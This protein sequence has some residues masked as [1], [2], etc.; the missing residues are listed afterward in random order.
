MFFFNLFF[1]NLFFLITP[2]LRLSTDVEF[3]NL[4]LIEVHK[5]WL[6]GVMCVD[7][8]DWLEVLEWT[9]WSNCVTIQMWAPV[10]AGPEYRAAVCLWTE[11]ITVLIHAFNPLCSLC[12]AQHW[13]DW[14]AN[15]HYYHV[16][17]GCHWRI[18]FLAVSGNSVLFLTNSDMF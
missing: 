11:I 5:V 8:S 12:P 9:D 6:G 2:A 18:R 15:L 3:I 7:W 13:C 10:C 16:F 14:S 17:A 1:L 4:E